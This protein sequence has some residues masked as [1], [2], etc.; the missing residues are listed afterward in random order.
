MIDHPEIRIEITQ[1]G[2]PLA[3]WDNPPMEGDT[4]TWQELHALSVT[5]FDIAARMMDKEQAI[6][7]SHTNR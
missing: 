1:A 3:I 2:I 4:H 7:D 5:L 6:K